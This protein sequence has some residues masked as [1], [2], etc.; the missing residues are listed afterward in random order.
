MCIC[1]LWTVE[2]HIDL[3]TEANYCQFILV[4]LDTWSLFIVCLGCS[5]SNTKL[6]VVQLFLIIG[7]RI[8]NKVSP[9]FPYN[10]ICIHVYAI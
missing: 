7:H 2:I 4:R 3:I 9:Y 6:P 5:H 10:I 1:K 8:L